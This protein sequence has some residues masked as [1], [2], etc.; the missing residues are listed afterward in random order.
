MPLFDNH[1]SLGA[2]GLQLIDGSGRGRDTSVE[3]LRLITSHL[4][5]KIER[6]KI[7]QGKNIFNCTNKE[8]SLFLPQPVVFAKA[9]G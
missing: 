6:K 9:K 3:V 1:L 4:P 5:P 7:L 8:C 2:A